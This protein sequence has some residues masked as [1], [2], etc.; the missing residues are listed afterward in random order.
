MIGAK[1]FAGALTGID[2]V[3]LLQLLQHGCIEIEAIFLENNF[4]IRLKLKGINTTQDM[5]FT[6]RVN[7]WDVSIFNT[8]QPSAVLGFG[9]AITGNGSNERAKMQRAG[10]RWRKPT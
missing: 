5:I 2:Q 9:I 4:G 6:A 3:A 1:H 8:Y 7:A 10:W